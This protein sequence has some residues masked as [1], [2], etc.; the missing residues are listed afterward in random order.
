M[1]IVTAGSPAAEPAPKLISVQKI[2]DEAPH[3]A[4]TD[5]IRFKG[6]WI[7]AF[8]EAPAHKGGVR[9]SSIR[10]IASDDTKRWEPLARMADARGDIR[11]AKMAILPDGRLMLLTAT[12]LFD[13]SGGQ[14]H[15]SI[16]FFSDDAKTWEGPVDVGEPNIWLWGIRWH[17]GAGYS[18]GYGTAGKRLAQLYRTTDGRQFDRVGEK[19]DVKS[20]HPNESAICFDADDTARVLLRFDPHPAN[21][22]SAKPPYTKW[23]WKESNLR[24]GGPALTRTPGGKL[25]GGGRLYEPE[26]R[27]A[28]FWVDETTGKLTECVSMPSGGDT[29]YPGFAWDDGVL[30]VSYYASHEGKS[31]IYF[32][33]VGFDGKEAP[34]RK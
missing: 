34:R 23:E 9:D 31:S 4:F 17:K 22:G 12:Q 30:F 16:A 24:V 29:S 32:A 28:L 14:T 33:R 26:P 1:G 5:L 6:R 15:Q 13:Q 18:I 19:F 3:N 20:P 21:V 8:R 7:C 2:W 27:M 25:L 11:D 10:V